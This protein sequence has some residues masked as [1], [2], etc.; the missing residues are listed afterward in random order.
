MNLY[1]RFAA[2]EVDLAKDW[3]QHA[4]TADSWTLGAPI[5]LGESGSL[6]VTRHDGLKGIA[7]PAFQ[8]GPEVPRA[9]HEKIA[10]DL[11]YALEIPVPPVAL[12]ETPEGDLFAIS[13]R[14]FKQPL[15]WDQAKPLL[16]P[17]FQKNAAPVLAA[18]LVFHSW[19]GDTDH[20]GNGGNV[21]IDAA[22]T[23]DLPGV[24]FIDH[25]FSMSH[26]WTAVSPVV[27]LS[28]YYCAISDL[29]RDAIADVVRRVQ[30][31]QKDAISEVIWR[32][33]AIYLPESRAK[34]IEECLQ[35]RRLTIA[36]AFGLD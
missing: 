18:G 33:P 4:R 35:T 16:T 34:L 36:A 3:S 22:S 19:I 20:G 6:H 21:L 5:G 9:A 30:S 14:A 8:K 25:A 27:A 24:A 17:E 10:S 26:G 31:L 7:K 32:I 12:W 11:A 29:P 15:T 23:P 28:S 2:A 1:R 13:A